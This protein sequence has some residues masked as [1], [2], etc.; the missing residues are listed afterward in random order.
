MNMKKL[1][2]FLLLFVAP[3][4]YAQQYT[5][6]NFDKRFPDCI[7]HWVIIQPKDTTYSFGF[8]Y[9]DMTAG[10]TFDLAGSFSIK[11]TTF[12]VDKIKNTSIK[13]RLISQKNNVPVTILPDSLYKKLDIQATPDWFKFYKTDENSTQYLFT[14]GYTY[15]DWNECAKAVPFLEKAMQIN[16]NFVSVNGS[17]LTAELAFSYNCLG[18]YDKT[19]PVLQTSLK[20]DS[21]DAYTYKELIYAQIHSGKISEAEE[22]FDTAV[23]VCKN[24]EF[25]GENAYNILGFYFRKQDKKNF[26]KWLPAARKWN[27]NNEVLLNS[28][29]AM[30][31][32]INES[33]FL[34]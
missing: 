27:K 15:N 16:P 9:L 24:T 30:E 11:D 2:L 7:N 19:I 22:T 29:T 8:V 10:L 21:N 14:M 13:Y 3:K 33:G 20:N 17:K 26:E 6:G 5:V 23:N 25:N 28:I 32:K 34:N 31:N 12:I 18:E 4:L 1:S